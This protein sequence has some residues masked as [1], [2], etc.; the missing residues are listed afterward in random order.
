VPQIV[1]SGITSKGETIMSGNTQPNAV[2]PRPA[3]SALFI[4]LLDRYV[5]DA[6]NKTALDQA[7]ASALNSNAQ[8]KELLKPYIERWKAIPVERRR[9]TYGADFGDLRADVAIAPEV[10]ER[11]LR[12][13]LA[14]PL[15]KIAPG[16]RGTPLPDG[17]G[18]TADEPPRLAAVDLNGHG[19]VI[20]AANGIIAP[21]A[22]TL[23]AEQPTYRIDF[24]GIYCRKETSWDQG[25]NS[26]E[27]YVLFTTTQRFREPW[28][29]RSDVYD[30]V[31]DGIDSGNDWGPLP[32][33]L[34]LFG[35]SGPEV[36]DETA[37]TAMVMEHDQGDPN[38]YK[39]KVRLG[40]KAAQAI[41]AAYG[42]P[43]PDAVANFATEIINDL[44]NTGDDPIGVSS[45][46]LDAGAFAFY[47]QQPLIHFKVQLDYHF[48]TYHTDGDAK[49]Y[50]MYRVVQDPA[51]PV[52]VVAATAAGDPAGYTTSGD[53]QHVVYRGVD[54]HIHE[55]FAGDIWRTSTLTVA[56][57]A[58]TAAGDP[59]GYTTANGSIQHVVYRGGDGHIHELFAGDIWRHNDLTT[60][61]R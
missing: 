11:E 38:A 2:R 54:G 27:P 33:L 56:A 13:I 23:S 31:D 26:D 51:G 59:S 1:I 20:P 36:V 55:L 29:T 61:A 8:S 40:V 47:A 3:G 37:V 18:E 10:M 52:V 15:A 30:N 35:Q 53:V 5:N 60:A 9:A 46:V 49:Y 41:A 45:F 58:P 19:A 43:I 32:P 22:A 50:V 14:R 12:A 4:H 6:P 17:V 44:L 57:G 48:W 39:E 42:I 24:A 28:A 7:I 34:S 21:M 25:T 16:I